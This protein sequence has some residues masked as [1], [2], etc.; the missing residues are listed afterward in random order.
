MVTFVGTSAGEQFP[1]VWCNCANCRKSRELGGKNLRR[2][3]SMFMEP[4]ILI[5]FPPAIPDQ[6][7]K[8]GVELPD[9]EHLFITHNH[10]D[11]FTP[12]F[13]RWRYFPR[14][15]KL[16]PQVG[17]MGPL[18]SEPKLLHVYGNQRVVD[19]TLRVIDNN[20]GEHHMEI[21]IMETGK[22]LEINSSLAALPIRGNHDPSQ[23][24]LNYIFLRD[25]QTI[26]YA[27]DT[28][29]FLPETWEIIKQYQYDLVVMDGT[30][31][32]NDQ[33]D[34]T[35]PGHCNFHANK[36]A[37]DLFGENG[38]LKARAKFV[39]THTGPHHAPPYEEAAPRLADMGLILAYD[40][41]KM[42]I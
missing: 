33:Y 27:T 17:D 28:G 29:W 32:F 22:L 25:N 26:L 10:D 38:M 37:L 34:V 41:M 35:G 2:N 8:A 21:H 11:H 42:D 13:F 30:F 23:V 12:W 24:C 39:I 20:P 14:E 40:G 4:N 7:L 3:A 6:A 18:F 5:D 1:G 19:E 16:P 36:R 15:R 31:G 9:I